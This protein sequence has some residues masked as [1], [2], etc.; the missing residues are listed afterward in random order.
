MKAKCMWDGL[1][2]QKDK[3]EGADRLEWLYPRNI[4]Q[5]TDA[6]GTHCKSRIFVRC[7]SLS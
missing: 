4:K 7:A 3:D 5:F 6:F 1:E 2:E